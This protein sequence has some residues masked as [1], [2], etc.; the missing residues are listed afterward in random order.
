MTNCP[1]PES[2]NTTAMGQ[3]RDRSQVK[4]SCEVKVQLASEYEAKTATFASAVAGLRGNIG[5]STKEKYEQ[6]SRIANDAR[7]NSEQARLALEEHTAKH[8]C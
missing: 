1:E 3:R 6:L 5:T 2:T 4:M 7:M 8:H